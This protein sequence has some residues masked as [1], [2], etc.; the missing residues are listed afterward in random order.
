MEATGAEVNKQTKEEIKQWL[1][2][3]YDNGKK[4]KIS[5]KPNKEGMFEVTYNN[6]N[7]PLSQYNNSGPGLTN[8]KFVFTE[9]IGDFYVGRSCTS[10]EGAPRIVKGMF[11]CGDKITS[12]VGGPEVVDTISINGCKNIQSFE[13]FPMEVSNSFECGYANISNFVGIGDSKIGVI[14]ISSCDNLKSLKG[15]DNIEV[16]RINISNCKSFESFE[17]FPVNSKA[18]AEKA[19]VETANGDFGG[20][21]GGVVE[22]YNAPKLNAIVPI[23]NIGNALTFRNC[24]N[25]NFESYK[26]AEY[27]HQIDICIGKYDN[28]N[29]D[30]VSFYEECVNNGMKS[31]EEFENAFKDEFLKRGIVKNIDEVFILK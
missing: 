18:M 13:G 7:K 9:V 20:V 28:P 1:A 10:L 24:P 15:L 23:K 30:F 16:A 31:R 26:G 29:P 25:V 5:S 27:I 2:N 4:C 12:F 6:A 21:S 22:V 3:N 17:G 14:N 11:G 19:K 8:G